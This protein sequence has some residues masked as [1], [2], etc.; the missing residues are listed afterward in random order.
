MVK[1]GAVRN[2]LVVGAEI[3]SRILDWNDRGTC[4]LFGD[5]AGAVVLMPSATPGILSA[6]LH[7]DGHYQE[8][9]CVPGTVA[10]GVVRGRPFLH[11]DGSAVFKFAVKV[12][13]EVAHEALDREP[14]ARERNRLVDSASS[15]HPHH[16][17]NLEETRAAAGAHG[18]DGRYACQYVGG[19]D[20]IGARRRGP[21]RAHPLWTPRHAGRRRRRIHLGFGADTM[22]SHVSVRVPNWNRGMKIAMVFPGQGSQSVGMLDGYEAYPMVRETLA[23]AGT[24]LGA[25][26]VGTRGRGTRRGTEPDGEHTTA[27]AGGRRRRL[28]CVDRQPEVRSRDYRRTQPWRICRARRR[29]SAAIRRRF[30]AG[31]V[32]CAGDAGSSARGRRRHGRDH[33]QGMRTTR[34]SSP[35]AARKRRRDRWWSA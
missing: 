5:G 31:A 7:A 32:S 14:V 20:S 4:V 6:H 19:V 34:G 10:N 9:L 15:Q 13:A 18:V 28:S 3:Y 23:E 25:G 11:M 17:C 21:R 27:D 24:T 22:V 35:Q 16:G 26:P 1:S 29:R 12:L 8:I 2:A 30:A 33:E